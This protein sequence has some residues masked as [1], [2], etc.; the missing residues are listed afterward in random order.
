MEMRFIGDGLTNI[1]RAIVFCAL[2]WRFRNSS[3]VGP[4]PPRFYEN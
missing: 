4:N 1:A 3:G 2:V